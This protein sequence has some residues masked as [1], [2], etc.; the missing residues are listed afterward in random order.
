MEENILSPDQEKQVEIAA[1]L[2][3]LYDLYWMN[4]WQASG[5]SF[6]GDHDFFKEAYELTQG[7]LDSFMER[8]AFADNTNTNVFLSY[9]MNKKTYFEY[10][11]MLQN[12]DV[13]SSLLDSEIA[14]NVFIDDLILNA[15]DKLSQGSINLLAD[16][17]DKRESL[18]YKIKRRMF[19]DRVANR[20]AHKVSVEYSF[21]PIVYSESKDPKKYKAYV[22]FQGIPVH[23]EFM[24]GEKRRGHDMLYS[25]GE[26]PN[27]EG[28]D[29]DCLDVYLGNNLD[30]LIVVVIHQ[31]NPDTG[32]YDEDKVMLGFDSVEEALKAYGN[33]Y[34]SKEGFFGGYTEVSTSTFWRWVTEG[35][36]NKKQMG[37]R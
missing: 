17:S 28:F 27:T 12:G 18:I 36:Y 19:K 37:S 32:E 4:H 26:I 16:I 30:S 22:Q 7:Q 23:V 35:R 3:A 24:A 5:I 14:L 21:F 25:Y 34:S 20:K 11:F 1:R 33:Q 2:F 9:V 10:Y 29:G 6:F 31:N 13:W 15:K 8:F